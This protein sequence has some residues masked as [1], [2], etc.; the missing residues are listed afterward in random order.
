MHFETPFSDWSEVA[1]LLLCVTIAV[2]VVITAAV[3]VLITVQEKL[4]DKEKKH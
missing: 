4:L 1:I 3:K 2:P